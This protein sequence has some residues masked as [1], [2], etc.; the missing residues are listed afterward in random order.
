MQ[1]ILIRSFGLFL[2]VLGLLLVLRFLD[3]V[4]RLINGY[5]FVRLHWIVVV[6]R[7]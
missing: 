3:R 5:G 1:A 7:M 2:S 4:L 6:G